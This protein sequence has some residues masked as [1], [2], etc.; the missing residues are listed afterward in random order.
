MDK[1]SMCLFLYLG[2][3]MAATEVLNSMKREESRN[4]AYL[5]T[6]SAINI[7]ND[8]KQLAMLLA[9]LDG[10]EEDI[11]EFWSSN[12]KH[13]V[14]VA[15]PQGKQQ[16]FKAACKNMNLMSFEGYFLLTP[17]FKKFLATFA[18]ESI[19]GKITV[20]VIEETSQNVFENLWFSGSFA[21]RQCTKAFHE[22]KITLKK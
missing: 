1:N 15:I 13:S 10:E 14:S 19:I 9:Y 16:A 4:P 6:R 7:D 3:A 5:Q 2:N 22:W 21:I 18:S 8:V 11:E 12:V 20:K 17:L